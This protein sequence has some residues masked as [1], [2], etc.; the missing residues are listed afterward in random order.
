VTEEVTEEVLL[1]PQPARGGTASRENR[2]ACRFMSYHLNDYT[3]S[4]MML[5]GACNDIT[6]GM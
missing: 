1:S 2:R 3:V 6:S 5:H 4:V